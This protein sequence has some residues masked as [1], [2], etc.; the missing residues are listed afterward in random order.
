MIVY[1]RFLCGFK[2]KKNQNILICPPFNEHVGDDGDHSNLLKAN[3][4]LI[5]FFLLGY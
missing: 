1:D 5:D 4:G 2:E 3:Q